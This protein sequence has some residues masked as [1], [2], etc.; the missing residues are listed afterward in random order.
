M[1]LTPAAPEHKADREIVV[2][3]AAKQKGILLTPAAP[4][5]KADREIV[6]PLAAKQKGIC[7]RRRHQSTRRTV[8]S[9]L[10]LPLSRKDFAYPCGTRAQGG[11]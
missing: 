2:P 3:L 11:L 6:A 1:L 8:R 7:L 5:H 4:E 9:L 10:L